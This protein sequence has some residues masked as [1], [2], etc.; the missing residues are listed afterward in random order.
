MSKVQAVVMAAI[1]I[2]VAG[3]LSGCGKAAEPKVEP[4]VAPP[5]IAAAGTLKVGVDMS[6]PPFAGEDQGRKAGL[7]IDVAAALADRL[8]LKVVY[9]D[10]KPSDAAT[11]LAAGTADAVMSVPLAD[12]AAVTQLSLAGSYVDNGPG[13]FVSTGSTA[14]VEPSLTID[15]IAGRVAAQEGSE[16]FWVLRSELDSESVAPYESLRAAIEALNA[17]EEELVAGDILTAAYIARDF[18]E[19][20]LAGQLRPAQPLAVAVTAENTALG[21]AIRTELDALAADGVIDA[22]RRKWVGTLPELE[23]AASEESGT[24]STEETAAP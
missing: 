20:H 24:V 2:L 18:P 23:T 15:S 13:L 17:G 3:S 8:G 7:D 14:S 5:A 1:S 16:S 4:K 9:V 19:I 6:Q 12:A 22:L 21:E 11:A 10:V